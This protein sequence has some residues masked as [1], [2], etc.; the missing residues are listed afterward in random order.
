M[1]MVAEEHRNK[2]SRPGVSALTNS[3]ASDNDR[4]MFT[5]FADQKH[6]NESVFK[7]CIVLIVSRYNRLEKFVIL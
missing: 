2:M 1:N 6:I 3:V 4:F 7:F 5:C